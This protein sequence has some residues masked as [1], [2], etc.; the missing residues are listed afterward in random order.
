MQWQWRLKI[1][2]R[3]KERM[4]AILVVRDFYYLRT[5]MI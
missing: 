4:G 2:E 1:H 3:K 5:S